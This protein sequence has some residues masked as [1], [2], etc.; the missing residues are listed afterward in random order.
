M[1]IRQ[2]RHNIYSAVAPAEC[3]PFQKSIQEIKPVGIPNYQAHQFFD[4]MGC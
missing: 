4:R 3:E 2:W 1:P